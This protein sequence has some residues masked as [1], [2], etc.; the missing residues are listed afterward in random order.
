MMKDIFVIIEL[1]TK[2]GGSHYFGISHLLELFG[3]FQSVGVFNK[4]Y[5]TRA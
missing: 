1:S 5:I 4:C 2:C 3:I